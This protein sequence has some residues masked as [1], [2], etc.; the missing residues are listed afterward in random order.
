MSAIWFGTAFLIL[1]SG[2][3]LFSAGSFAESQELNR[4]KVPVSSVV[5]EEAESGKGGQIQVEPGDTL[6]SNLPT[7][8]TFTSPPPKK[9]DLTGF[10]VIGAII[11]IVVLSVFG[12]WA[13]RQW[14]KTGKR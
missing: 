4:V 14:K 12:V 9:R 3:G 8:A 10:W 13:V 1:V 5:K 2:T 7:S 6:K 11:N